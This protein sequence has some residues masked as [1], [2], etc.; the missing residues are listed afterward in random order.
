MALKLLCFSVLSLQD[1]LFSW[2]LVMELQVWLVS[3]RLMAEG[4]DGKTAR[5]A[6]ISAL[7]DDT[8]AKIKDLGVR[9]TSKRADL[10]DMNSHL[11]TSLVSYDEGLL[12]S[13]RDLAGAVWRRLVRRLIDNEAGEEQDTQTSKVLENI[14]EPQADPRCLESLVSYIRQQVQLLDALDTDALL[15]AKLTWTQPSLPE[16]F[17]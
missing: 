17:T 3:V 11:Q 16:T 7:W 6:L 12:G 14:A 5:N 15:T 13:D 2:F 10:E 4:E 1:T 8:N 9:S